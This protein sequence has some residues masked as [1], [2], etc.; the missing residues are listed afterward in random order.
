MTLYEVLGIG[1]QASAAEIK[2]AHREAVK[3]HHPDAGGDPAAF[4]PPQPPYA[5]LSHPERRARYD[6]TGVED[7]ASAAEEQQAYG[8]IAALIM[9][10]VDGKEDLDRTDVVAAVRAA[11]EG[12]DKAHQLAR[13]RIEARIARIGVLRARR[14]SSGPGDDALATLLAEREAALEAARTSE[15]LALRTLARALEVLRG[16]SYRLD[17]TPREEAAI[18]SALKR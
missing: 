11:L 18:W 7:D 13:R 15:S 3:A 12:Q 4:L 10:V 1:E 2:A 17:P 8:A 16:Y 14:R 6:S 9:Q 5:V